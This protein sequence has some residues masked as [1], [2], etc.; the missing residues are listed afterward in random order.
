[1]NVGCAIQFIRKLMTLIARRCGGEW[2][3]DFP[4]SAEQLKNCTVQ[5]LHQ[6]NPKGFGSLQLDRDFSHYQ[7]IM[8]WYKMPK[9]VGGTA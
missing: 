7:D 6:S 5:C 2:R 9:S 8:G 4:L 1:M 3:V